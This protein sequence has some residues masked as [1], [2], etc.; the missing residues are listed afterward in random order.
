[1]H[2]IVHSGKLTEVNTEV[3]KLVLEWRDRPDGEPEDVMFDI[4]PEMELEMEWEHL[5]GRKV[6]I[7]TIDDKVARVTIF[8]DQA[9]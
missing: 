6:E 5:M 7:L 2:A 8:N 9:E 3:G 4:E 1:M